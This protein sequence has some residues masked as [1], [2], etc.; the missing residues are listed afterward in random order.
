MKRLFMSTTGRQISLT[1]V[2][3]EIAKSLLVKQKALM[4]APR[5]SENLSHAVEGHLARYFRALDRNEPDF[6][7]YDRIL[8]EV[9]RPLWWQ[10]CIIHWEIK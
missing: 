1:V 4:E 8:A 9:E 3:K 10:R 7:L 6:G 2:E 5:A